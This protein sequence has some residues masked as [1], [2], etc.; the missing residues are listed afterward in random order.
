MYAAH[1]RSARIHR[2]SPLPHSNI[3]GITSLAGPLRATPME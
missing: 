2:D 1:Q 3:F